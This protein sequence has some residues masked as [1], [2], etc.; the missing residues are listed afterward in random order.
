MRI[1]ICNTD[2]FCQEKF[3]YLAHIPHEKNIDEYECMLVKSTT[4]VT[5]IDIKIHRLYILNYMI[6]QY[7]PMLLFPNYYMVA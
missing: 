3:Y 6:W 5:F 2:H 7:N 1:T 4:R